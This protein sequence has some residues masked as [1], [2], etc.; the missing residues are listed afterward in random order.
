MGDVTFY[1]GRAPRQL[2][3]QSRVRIDRLRQDRE[4]FALARRVAEARNISLRA[5]TAG[6]QN[7]GHVGLSR[8]MAMYL[9][10]TLLGRTQEEVGILFGRTHGT[11]SYACRMVETLRDDPVFDFAIAEIEAE[12]AAA[13]RLRHAA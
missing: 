10:H 12:Y 3:P 2:S 11:V 5:L 9:V 6:G 8:R 13:G 4:A 1:R 7:R